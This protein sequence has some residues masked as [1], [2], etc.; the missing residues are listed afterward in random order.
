MLR[1]GLPVPP[2]NSDP[3]V[4]WQLT[5]TFSSR[6]LRAPNWPPLAWRTQFTM[7]PADAPGRI[8]HV[9]FI[10]YWYPG[11]S[12]EWTTSEGCF[13][14]ITAGLPRRSIRDSRFVDAVP[15]RSTLAENEGFGGRWHGIALRGRRVRAVRLPGDFPV[16]GHRFKRASGFSFRPFSK[17]G[18]RHPATAG[19][20][21]VGPFGLRV[22]RTGGRGTQRPRA[23]AWYWRR[24]DSGQGRS[25]GS[26]SIRLEWSSPRF[27]AVEPVGQD[28]R[29]TD[30]AR[31]R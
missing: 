29:R 12:W 19:G 14:R 1:S 16:G 23:S 8:S 21:A 15:G 6:C 5:T 18:G 17:N 25:T 28:A 26:G 24:S 11:T 7:S 2:I 27:P 20:R 4:P 30:A 13:I 10:R 3:G 31:A 9:H 22:E